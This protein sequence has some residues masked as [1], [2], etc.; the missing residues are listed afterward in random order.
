MSTGAAAGARA[1]S[2]GEIAVERERREPLEWAGW[3]ALFALA[4]A[5][6]VYLSFNAGGFFPSAPGFA[7]IVFALALIL[8]TTLAARPF[9]GFS[10]TLAVPLASA[11]PVRRLA[12]RLDAVVARDRARAGRV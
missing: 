2:P 8:R 1:G 7:A 5:L 6:I 12:T 4:P 11:R 9:E 3:I 10:R